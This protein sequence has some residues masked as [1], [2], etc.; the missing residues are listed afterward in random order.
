MREDPLA[1]GLGTMSSAATG[2][3]KS[4]VPVFHDEV[5]AGGP[6][7]RSAAT[8]ALRRVNVDASFSFVKCGPPAPRAGKIRL[9]SPPSAGI[10]MRSAFSVWPPSKVL[11]SLS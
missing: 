8:P 11:F 5:C 2:S 7:R 3:S 10:Q 1:I 4:T 6:C 9:A